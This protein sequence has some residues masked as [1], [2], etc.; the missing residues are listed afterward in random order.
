MLNESD[1]SARAVIRLTSAVL[2]VLTLEAGTGQ[3][4]HAQTA[5]DT[6]AARPLVSLS[7]A[8]RS[9]QVVVGG[10]IEMCIVP[11]SGTAYRINA[12]GLPAQCLSAAHTRLDLNLSGPTG[13]TGP[14]GLPGERGAKGDA[15]AVGP[16]GPDG[17]ASAPGPAGSAGPTGAAGSAGAAGPTGATGS[18][19]RWVPLD[20]Q[21][22]QVRLPP[23]VTSDSR[24][25]T[26]L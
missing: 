5:G 7:D 9:T 11:G 6:V 21:A 20:Q 4:L 13:L 8:P 26:V 2:S 10:M 12:P 19:V 16:A 23:L 25:R 18:V 14:Q 17:I 1:R 15:G 3:A 22:R 24:V